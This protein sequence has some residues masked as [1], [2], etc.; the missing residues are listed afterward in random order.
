[1]MF[2]VRSYRH[3]V[4]GITYTDPIAI[5]CGSP[6]G[7]EEVPVRVHDACWTSEVCLPLK[8]SNSVRQI[9]AALMKSDIPCRGLSVPSRSM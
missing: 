8:H 7:R 3:T 4:D 9:P 5:M 2:R 6:E 1:M